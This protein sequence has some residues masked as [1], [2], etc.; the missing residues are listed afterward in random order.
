[1]LAILDGRQGG[2]DNQGVPLHVKFD[3]FE[4]PVGKNLLGPTFICRVARD[5]RHE[6]IGRESFARRDDVARG[7]VPRLLEMKDAA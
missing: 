4:S 3:Q 5:F 6:G 1:M 7:G 2:S